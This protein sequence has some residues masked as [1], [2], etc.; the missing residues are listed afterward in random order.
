MSVKE[1][2]IVVVG[3]GCC[4]K[5]PVLEVLNN[6][7]YFE[8]CDYSCWDNYSQDVNIDNIPYRFHIWDTAGQDEFDRIRPLSYSGADAIL[9]CFSLDSKSS[10]YNLSEKWIGELNH[11]CPKAKIIL[12]GT[13]SDLRITGNK[14][15]ITDQEA[16]QF[17]TENNCSAFIPCSAKTGE[18]INEIFPAVIKAIDDDAQT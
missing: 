8:R 18:G 4:E 7:P 17:L 1:V 13:K 16:N 10:L 15:H 2:K 11:H 6:R 3:D 14:N 12:I 5:K 9:L